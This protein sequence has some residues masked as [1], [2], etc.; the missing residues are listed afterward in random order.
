MPEIPII[1]DNQPTREA[2]THLLLS[3]GYEVS[4]VASTRQAIHS[5]QEGR[6]PDAIIADYDLGGGDTGVA[7]IQAVEDLLGTSVSA[8]MITGEDLLPELQISTSH[9]PIAPVQLEEA[10]T[11]LLAKR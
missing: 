2:Y 6:M 4:S 3:W 7:A 9:K 1:E 5:I 8:V 11:G 10:L